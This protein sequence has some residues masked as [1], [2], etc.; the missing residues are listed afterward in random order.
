M[1]RAVTRAALAAA[2][3]AGLA[4][5]LPSRQAEARPSQSRPGSIE[6]ETECRYGTSDGRAGYSTL[7]V[8]R[9]IRCA[10]S[11]WSV[12][13]GYEQAVDVA[14]CESGSD[15]FDHSTDGYAGTFQQSTRYWSGRRAQYNPPAWDKPLQRPVWNPRANVV[16]S[17]RMAHADGA[18]AMSDG[19]QWADR[20]G[21]A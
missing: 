7:D 5:G 18:W 3:L 20:C 1:K 19:G 8:R 10:V 13:G 14:S 11:K 9:V 4:G 21:Y 17:I 6:R 15:L 2:I 16:V 12:P